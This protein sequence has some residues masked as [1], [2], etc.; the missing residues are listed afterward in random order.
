MTIFTVSLLAVCAVVYE[1]LAAAFISNP[2][3]NA[4]ILVTLAFGVAAAYRQISR[5]DSSVRWIHSFKG[6]NVPPSAPPFL[7]V[8]IASVL[9]KND[10]MPFLGAT[11]LRAM[12]DGVFTRVDESRDLSRYL[13]NVLILLGLLGTFWGLLQTVAGIGNVIGGLTVGEGDIK[14]VFD[15]FKEGLR[16]PLLGMGVSFSA[17]L[18]GL[19]SS[20]ILGFLD[21]Q[22]GRAQ[23][24]FCAELEEWLGRRTS[25]SEGLMAQA[26][27][28]S[29]SYN[30][31]LIS[32][33]T[34]QL[35]RLQ[36][37]MRQQHENQI[38]EQGHLRSLA[39]TVAALND[40]VKSHHV[41][42]AKLTQL[43]N[44]TTPALSQLTEVIMT[45][46]ASRVEEHVRSVDISLKEI[47]QQLS[48]SADNNTTLLRDELRTIA[49]LIAAD[50]QKNDPRVN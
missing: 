26:G 11:T 34:D 37:T 35:E 23:N 2:Y 8:P 16:K 30:E 42:L 13:M 5:I 12:L 45:S 44:E 29:G 25:I 31:A 36:R 4:G 27:P 7:L 32:T 41:L 47:S 24:I 21:L 15:G 49:R 50:N 20:L 3:F 33:L 39:E 1:R 18:F 10:S 28:A 38:S 19:A 22:T 14:T 40:N 17:S 9:Q 46:N 6:A 43:Q 48:N